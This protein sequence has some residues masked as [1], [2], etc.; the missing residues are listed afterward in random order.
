MKDGIRKNIIKILI[1][2]SASFVLLIGYLS[3][4]EIR[5]GEALVSDPKNKRNIDKEYDVLRGSIYDRK[6]NLVADS[7][8]QADNSQKRIYNKDL[9]MPYAPVLGYFSMKYGTSGLEKSYSKELLND[10]MLNPFKLIRDIMTR[11]DRKGNGL[12]LTIDSN[13]Q[14]AAYDALG[15]NRGA[16][17]AMDPKTGEILCMVSKPTFNPSTIDQD[18]NSLVKDDENGVLLNRAIQPGIYPPGSTFKVI[19]ASEALENIQDIESKK[20]ADNGALKIGN[21]TLHNYANERFG[22]IDIHKA[23]TVSS[24]IVFGQIGMEIGA[25]RLKKGAE[26]FY[27][28]KNIPFDLQVSKSQFPS[29]SKDRMDS[30]A[31][32]SIG[33]YEVRVTPLQM[34]LS[35]SAIANDGVIMKPY[36]VKS[37]I[38]TYGWNI[39]STKPKVLSQP[40]LKETADK[41]NAMMV[42]VVKKGTGKKAQVEGIDIAG[43]TGTA[44]VGEGKE[45]HSWFIAFA[46]AKDP[47]IAIAIIV[48][49][50]ETGGG[51][52][53]SIS[54][55]LFKTYLNR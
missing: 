43:K 49:N 17:V 19:V 28:N 25:D 40:I 34:L 6:M 53:A 31:Q 37:V 15:N 12:V 36:L 35:V 27:F 10:N 33:Q 55:T 54:G 23:F 5:Y 7:Q 45:P 9:E 50:G 20:Y 24:N 3:Y 39:R 30:L 47:K 22:R 14:K 38:D 16:I 8:R 18:W 29:I 48:E 11:A 51:K 4:F 2:F 1:V 41:V 46:P 26:D 21:Y 42:D 13:L 52:A 32:S 44:D